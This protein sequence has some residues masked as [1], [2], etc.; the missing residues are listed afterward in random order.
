MMM[1]SMT[2]QQYMHQR[3]DRPGIDGWMNGIGS[4][5]IIDRPVVVSIGAASTTTTMTTLV[6]KRSRRRLPD[7][8]QS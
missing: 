4:G 6:D 7:G 3:R 2:N 1:M 5:R 8:I